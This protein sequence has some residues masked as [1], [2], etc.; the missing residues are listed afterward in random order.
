MEDVAGPEDFDAEVYLR[1]ADERELLAGQDD[2]D[3]I[4]PLAAAAYALV[5]I[6]VAPAE[7]AQAVM[8]DYR[9]ARACREPGPPVQ[10]QFTPPP[11]KVIGPLRAVP[12]GRVI[13]QSWG[14]LTIDFIV[15]GE[16]EITLHV[17]MRLTPPPPPGP[18]CSIPRS[19]AR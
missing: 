8:D 11:P 2:A 7:L 9:F 12:C 1:L 5:A 18:G 4:S 19:W 6:G 15:L 17:R 10:F 16:H 13:E 3:R 14:W